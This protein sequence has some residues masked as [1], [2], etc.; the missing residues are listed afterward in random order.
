MFEPKGNLKGKQVLSI[1]LLLVIPNGP[2][3]AKEIPGS[4]C[5]FRC[6]ASP[7]D[8]QEPSHYEYD[9]EG[10]VTF[11]EKFDSVFDPAFGKRQRCSNTFTHFIPSCCPWL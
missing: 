1:D 11:Y 9:S 7:R 5:I 2:N 8:A 3:V 10:T 4:I 6:E